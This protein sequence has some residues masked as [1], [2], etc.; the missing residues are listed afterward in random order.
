MSMTAHKPVTSTATGPEARARVAVLS[1]DRA[2]VLIVGLAAIVLAALTWNRWGDLTLDTGYD[3]VVGAKVSHLNAPYMDYQYWYGPLGA[4]LLGAIYEVVGIAIWPS[5]ALG[6]VLAAAGLTLSYALARRL[7]GPAAAAAA[8]VLVAATAFSSSNISWVQPHTF[9][10]P[11]G[12]L[13]DLVVVLAAAR[14]AQVGTRRW[15]VVAGVATGL[16]ATTRPEAFLAALLALGVWLAVRLVRAT[17]RRTALREIA[18]VAAGAVAV[19]ALAYG[20]FLVVG[21]FHHHSLTLGALIHD[22]L[23]PTGLLRESV[24]TIYHDLAPR[25]PGSL[26]TLAGKVVLYGAGIGGTVVLA[27][28]IDHGGRRRVLALAA[29]GLV[30]AGALALLVGRPETLRFYLK[31]VFGWLP[32]GAL[33]VSALLARKALSDRGAGWKPQ[34]Q[35]ELLVALMLFGYAYSAYAKFW[36]VPNPGFAQNSL[37]GM[38]FVAAFLAVLHV[39]MV[40][41]VAGDPRGTLRT[42]GTAWIAVI[43]IALAGL[44]VH[45][46]REETF[47][48][49]GVAGTMKASPEDG[50]LFQQAVDVIQANTR[51]SEPILLA[52]QMTSLY[53]LTDRGD[54]LP[55]LSLLPGALDGPAAEA[56]AIRNLN[57][58]RLRLAI[59]DR[60]PLE[61]YGKG[62][63][64]VGYDQRLGRW[65]RTNFTHLTTLR[66][67]SDGAPRILDVWLRRTL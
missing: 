47:T 55:Q 46:A 43:A 42:L 2:S 24:S 56:R 52:P 10:A 16:A 62:A 63:F 22:N 31:D 64:G 28:A 26:V 66:G 67:T 45:D 36:P 65:I 37:Y 27:R 15:L 5:V 61:R 12:V 54:M 39:R 25:T 20:T 19:P 9:N 49:R 35:L 51:L 7:A 17:D 29:C 6:L 50:K 33:I 41:R 57:I 3:L 58:V 44:V 32:A 8:G 14:F 21:H 40:P 38:P 34:S 48:V 1:A 13:C 30:A 23:F 4:L 60:T 59:T 11:L 18:I 53:V